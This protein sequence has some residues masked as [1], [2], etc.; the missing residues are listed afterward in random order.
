MVEEFKDIIAG[1][2]QRISLYKIRLNDFQKKRDKIEDEIKTVKRYLELAETLYRVEVEKARAATTRSLGNE[3]ED[4]E[5]DKRESSDIILLEKTRFVGLSVPQGTF[6]LL[7]EAGKPLHAKEI[8][9]K[10]IEGGVR[11]RSKTP[12]TSV[13]ISLSRDK[14]F[15]KSGPN[16]F[17]L[18][19][20]L[21]EKS[22]SGTVEQRV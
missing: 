7:K 11:I 13:A 22:E 9:H 15:W 12:V 10:L 4:A 2:E 18:V 6:L 21:E 14:R 20:V 16:T 19:E 3:S 17:R 5:K 1:L 8:H